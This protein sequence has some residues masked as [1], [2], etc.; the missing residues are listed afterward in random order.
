V[1]G[2]AAWQKQVRIGR[3][4]L[5]C[6]V[7]ASLLLGGSLGSIACVPV[8]ASGQDPHTEELVEQLANPS[9]SERNEARE[10][11]LSLGAAAVPPLIVATQSDNAPL[12]WEAVN[13]LGILGDLRATAAVLLVALTDLDVHARWRANWAIT[14]LD[15]GLV[16]P[17]LIAALEGENQ[18]IAWNAAVTL[19]LFGRT[20]AVPLLHQGLSSSGWRR[21]EAVNAL[22]RVWNDETVLELITLLRR[23]PEDVRKEATL[24]LGRIGGEHAL[25]ALL[26]ALASDPSPEVRWRAA[27]MITRVGTLANARLLQELLEMETDS[28]VIEYIEKAITALTHL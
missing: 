16:V 4:L 24:S 7:V 6:A 5:F 15:D 10:G 22:G 12:R 1:T 8:E 28:L 25:L 11:L 19:S 27:M 21:W 13:L 18:T 9:A 14:R 2:E 20:E 23:G 26:E 17:R 3:T